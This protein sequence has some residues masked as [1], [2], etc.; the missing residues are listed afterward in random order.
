MTINL[1]DIQNVINFVKN[2]T[3]EDDSCDD[4]FNGPEFDN[5]R[6]TFGDNYL[7]IINVIVTDYGNKVYGIKYELTP[8]DVKNV[9][10]VIENNININDSIFDN[11]IFD[12]FRLIYGNDYINII[13]SIITEYNNSKLQSGGLLPLIPIAG[14]AAS[15]LAPQIGML[16]GRRVAMKGVQKV[17]QRA[18]R[19]KLS[20]KKR[21]KSIKRKA[22][23]IKKKVSKKARKTSRKTSKKI[24]KKLKN[25]KKSRQTDDDDDDEQNDEH[26]EQVTKKKSSWF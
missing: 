22:K 1:K 10:N 5:L 15:S 11:H 6:L 18:L 25:K 17:A 20:L 3:S 7:D 2:Y 26:D 9:I 13:H 19:K 4:T 23:K 14:A 16:V 8:S 12:N 24:S 21:A